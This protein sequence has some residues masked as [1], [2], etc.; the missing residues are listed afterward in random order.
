[1]YTFLIQDT[2]Q[3]NQ[4][5]SSN[6]EEQSHGREDIVN[7]NPSTTVTNDVYNFE[8]ESVNTSRITTTIS[9]KHCK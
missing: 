3:S 7:Q 1:M 9:A 5:S 8:L 6:G 4:P 2:Q